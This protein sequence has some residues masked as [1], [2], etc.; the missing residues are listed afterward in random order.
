MKNY[1]YP[2]P[3]QWLSL[4]ERPTFELT[5]LKETVKGILS[6]VRESRDKVLLEMSERYDG[7]QLK[8][9]TIDLSQESFVIDADLAGAIQIAKENI[10]KF[11]LSQKEEIKKVET[12]EG[13]N[14]WRKSVAIQN[15][16]LYIPGGSAPLFSTLLMLAIPAKIA[17][18][19]NIVVCT[20]PTKEGELNKV[21][22]WTCQL[23]GIQKIYLTGGAQAVAAMTFGTE[24]VPKVDKIFGPGNQYV[25]A[26]K[27]MTQNYGVAID[28][29][30][31]P[32]EVLV[33]ADDSAYPEFVAADLLSQA[34]HG[35]DSQVVLVSDSEKMI[36]KVEA[37]VQKQAEDLPRKEIAI[38]AL[39]NSQSILVKDMNE[40]VAFSNEYAPEHLIIATE[41]AEELGEQITI[42]GS[43]FLG[44]WSCESAG[45]YASGTN[46]TL[47]TNGYARNYSGVSLDSFVKKITFQKLTE[48][49][50][51][52][53]GPAIEKMAEAEQL[54]AH[55]N[56]V[57]LRLKR[58][59]N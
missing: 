16:G 15:V 25:T 6:E 51:Q 42:A 11:H 57:T 26:A 1:K 13:V 7:V 35:P 23:L 2:D 58:L 5:E 27:Q 36:S 4:C 34:E 59:T 28:I 50:I 55:K 52:N 10:E 44:N 47:P 21:I 18:C 8:K 9:L 17:G 22:G 14:C 46:H 40:A 20:P 33:I 12:V 38:K 41:N 31:G 37:E 19:K 30:A 39:E 24:S 32:S 54:Q 49:G 45:D 43:V 3:S 29:P 48:R 53:L 56:A